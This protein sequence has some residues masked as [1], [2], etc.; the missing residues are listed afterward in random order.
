MDLNEALGTVFLALLLA[1]L[2]PLALLFFAS[3]SVRKQ[4]QEKQ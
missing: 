2:V 1:A 3:I 4:E